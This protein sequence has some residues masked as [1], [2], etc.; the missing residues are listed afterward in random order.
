MKFKKLY[1]APCCVTLASHVSLTRLT[2]DGGDVQVD[3]V[4]VNLKTAKKLARQMLGA[5]KCDFM[6]A[7]LIVVM[8]AG[9]FVVM[10]CKSGLW[11]PR[12][13]HTVGT[14]YTTQNTTTSE[15]V[16][17]SGSSVTKG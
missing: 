3:E 12:V 10:S 7:F 6:R 8:C 16:S 15:L 9:I 11:C 14:L 4:E 2:R 1:A 5:A 13:E 17:L